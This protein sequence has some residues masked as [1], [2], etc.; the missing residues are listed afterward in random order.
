[1]THG[2]KGRNALYPSMNRFIDFMVIMQ[3]KNQAKL[4][5]LQTESGLR[6]AR[7]EA[8]IIAATIPAGSLEF[9]SIQ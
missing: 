4:G 2:Y 3:W 9:I 5:M 8:C 6:E 7:Q 1:M